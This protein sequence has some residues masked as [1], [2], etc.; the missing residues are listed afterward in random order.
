MILS[1]LYPGTV[2]FTILVGHYLN[3][4]ARTR[5]QDLNIAFGRQMV[6]GYL[7][8]QCL[9]AA[10]FCAG[11]QAA[12]LGHQVWRK[13]K[14]QFSWQFACF[15]NVTFGQYSDSYLPGTFYSH[16]SYCRYQLHKDCN[17]HIWSRIRCGICDTQSLTFSNRVC[18][19]RLGALRYET[20]QTGR[21]DCVDIK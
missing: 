5:V 8:D 4:S 7:N 18:N 9:N 1:Q 10:L 20:M 14:R 6:L 15:A 13:L 11:V 19:P 17:S 3:T 21:I 12:V 2:P 16:A